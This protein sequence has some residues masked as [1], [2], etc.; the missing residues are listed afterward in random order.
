MIGDNINSVLYYN[1]DEENIIK[2]YFARKA[3]FSQS[4]TCI[5]ALDNKNNFLIGQEKGHIDIL[6][7]EFM[8]L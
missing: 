8:E 4:V 1:I 7:I 6:N 5:V 3:N 2:P